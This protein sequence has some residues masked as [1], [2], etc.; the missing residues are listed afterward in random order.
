MHTAE[1][2]RWKVNGNTGHE[3]DLWPGILVQLTVL[4]GGMRGMQNADQISTFTDVAY[5]GESD[6]NFGCCHT[7]PL[8]HE[9]YGI[10]S[11]SIYSSKHRIFYFYSQL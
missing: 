8:S 1:S 9:E 6:A 2:L 7:R 4:W 10:I 11:E 3:Q 5:K